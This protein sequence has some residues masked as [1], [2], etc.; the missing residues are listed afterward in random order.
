MPNRALATP[1]PVRS[2]TSRT[3][4]AAFL[5]PCPT[6]IATRS[7]ALSTSAAA[8]MS[9][10]G[11]DTADRTWLGGLDGTCLNSCR[12]GVY[13]SSWR[14]PGTISAVGERDASAAL[15]ARSRALGNCSATLTSTRYSL[16]TSLNNVWRSTSC[17]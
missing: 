4:A 12:G 1:A 8:A 14:S 9:L 2:A 17:W 16:A 11:A 15:M 5:A 7:P 13:S 6:R 3:S 10:S